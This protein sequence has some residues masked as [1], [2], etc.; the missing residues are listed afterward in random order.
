MGSTEGIK[1]RGTRD[2]PALTSFLNEQLGKLSGEEIITSPVTANGLTELTDASFNDY[3]QSGKFFIKF[4]APWCGHCQVVIMRTA[5][6]AII[7]NL[8]LVLIYFHFCRN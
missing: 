7:Y 8:N 4:Y 5:Y 2:L 3:I 1:F 6:L